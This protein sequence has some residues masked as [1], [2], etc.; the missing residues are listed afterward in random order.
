MR[1]AVNLQPYR[2]SVADLS[3]LAAPWDG[4]LALVDLSAAADGEI[5]LPPCPVIGIGDPDHPLAAQ[6]D[7]VVEPPV[8][9]E[10]LATQVL[11]NPLA[12]QVIVGLLRL[13]PGLDAQAGLQAESLAYGVLQGSGEHARWLEQPRRSRSPPGTVTTSREDDRLDIVLQNPVPSAMGRQARD[14]VFEA[15]S[16]AVIDPSIQRIVL[17]ANGRGF[18]MGAD[19]AEFGTTRDPATAHAIRARTLP[20]HMAARCADRLEAD[21]AGAC[22]GAGLELA[23]W[24]HRIEAASDAWFQLPELAMGVLPGAGGCV[25]LTRRIGRQ[26]TAL[27]I[28][29][30]RRISA[31]TAL[32]WGLVDALV[33]QTAVD[34]GR[35]RPG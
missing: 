33:D 29:S 19:L 11:A 17:S 12:A 14:Q 35:K 9:L 25:S 15:L 27:M 16:L 26:R 5:A 2:A 13:L 6:L 23:A 31:R 4:P 32:A 1:N 20:A 10:G 24:A 22:V 30:G 7:C 28:L 18:S 8:T 21:I 34:P 3:P